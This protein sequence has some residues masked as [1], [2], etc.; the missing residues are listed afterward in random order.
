MLMVLYA[1]YWLVIIGAVIVFYRVA[2]HV[3]RKQK[4]D[5]SKQPLDDLNDSLI[6]T[7]RLKP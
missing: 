7:E 5:K 1:L 2:S 3:L 4:S 6:G